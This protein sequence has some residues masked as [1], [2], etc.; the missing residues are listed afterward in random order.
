WGLDK[1]FVNLKEG[2]ET[3]LEKQI[4]IKSLISISLKYIAP[5]LIFLVFLNSI[6][7]LNPIL[8]LFE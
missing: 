7:F 3:L 1:A 5:V 4:W 6:G 2:A 8:N